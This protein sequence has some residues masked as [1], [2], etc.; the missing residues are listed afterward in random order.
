MTN[1]WA[2]AKNKQFGEIS[3]LILV[4]S[5]NVFKAYWTVVVSTTQLKDMLLDSFPLVEPNIFNKLKP[6][7]SF[8]NN[9]YITNQEL[10]MI[11]CWTYLPQQVF[12]W[13]KRLGSSTWKEKKHR[14]MRK[15]PP[16]ELTKKK[17]RWNPGYFFSWKLD[18]LPSWLLAG[19][20][21]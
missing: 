4:A 7:L 6:P 5:K 10:L 12:T 8:S 1:M 13:K 20:S 19:I 11:Q 15:N 9:Q 17:T 16:D 21:F 18:V 2:V 14:V 3:F